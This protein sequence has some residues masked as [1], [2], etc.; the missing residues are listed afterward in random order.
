M[1]FSIVAR[2]GSS[3]GVAVASKF[4]AVGA[5]VPQ[6]RL[7]VGGVATQ[8]YAKVSYRAD[9]LRLLELG[10]SATGAV[11]RVTGADEGRAERQLG[12][13]AADSQATFT[14]PGCTDWAGGVAGELE[15]DGETTRY[16]IQ[17]NTLVGEQ[18]VTAMETAFLEAAGQPFPR[19]LLAALLAGD[20]AGGDSR[21]RQSAALVVTRPHAGYDKSGT[22]VDLRVDEHP[23]APTELVRLLDLN[24]LYFGQPEDLQ[25]LDP[26]LGAEV[27]ARLAALG[28]TQADV[29]AAL[30]SWSGVENYEMLLMPGHIDGRVLEKLREAASGVDVD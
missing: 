5:V 2:Q 28:H 20:A 7:E 22:E 27:T 4:L 23:Q 24:D 10:V 18:V 1:T 12:V 14:G 17:G 29:D 13:V 26:E 6:V 21:G 25:P 8:A 19:R 16:A 11:E 3:Y 15:E 30:A 9:V